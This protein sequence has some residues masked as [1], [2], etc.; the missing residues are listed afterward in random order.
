MHAPATRLETLTATFLE[1]IHRWGDVAILRAEVR[2]EKEERRDFTVTGEVTQSELSRALAGVAV[3]A[4]DARGSNDEVVTI[5]CYGL[6]EDELEFGFPYMFYGTWEEY[7]P[8]PN[9]WNRKPTAELQFH[10]RKWRK[11]RPYDKAGVIRWLKQSPGIGEGI[12][13]R[14]W[15]AYG[16]DAIQRVK[17]DPEQVAE[18]IGGGF[19]VEKAKMAAAHLLQN[20]Q[21]EAAFVD[22]GSLLDGRGFPHSLPKKLVRDYGGDAAD[23]VKRNPWLLLQ[24]RSTGVARTDK[25]Y[26]DLG[27]NPAAIKRQAIILRKCLLDAGNTTGD[28][29]QREA[30]A[31]EMLRGRIAGTELK[32]QKAIELGRRAKLLAIRWD[33]DMSLWLAE[34]TR[35]RHE[36]YIARRVARILN[37]HAT[38]IAKYGT[39]TEEKTITI[40][41]TRCT[42]CNRKLTAETVAILDEKPYGPECITK[43]DV[44]EITEKVPL[45]DWLS[46][47]AVTLRRVVKKHIGVDVLPNRMRMA[48]RFR[49]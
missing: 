3:D 47:S 6:D 5:K 39:V 46:Q 42:R 36:Q 10:A 43:I 15:T 21:L 38:K 40:D 23:D 13:I 26:L 24:Y 41:H 33:A 31:E 30:A 34:G 32:F 9:K 45:A 12:A 14:L 19:T 11:V 22:L 8:K 48:G 25:L 16:P 7:Q 35:A 29:W 20:D 28:T 44:G 49:T 17:D 1:E 37:P 27:G 4:L 2:A 18:E